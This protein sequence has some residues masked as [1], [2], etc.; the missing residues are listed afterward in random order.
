[1]VKKQTLKKTNDIDN[2]ISSSKDNANK[3][4]SIY[5]TFK[6]LSKWILRVIQGIIIGAGAIL[7]GISGGVLCVVFGLY[8]PMVAVLAPPI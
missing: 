2:I 4:N 1:M 5:K 7:P 8:Q 6:Y 3:H